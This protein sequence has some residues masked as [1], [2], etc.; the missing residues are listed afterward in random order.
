MIDEPAITT[1]E[2]EPLTESMTHRTLSGMFWLLSGSGVQA[3]LRIAV[4]VIVARLLVPADFGLVAGALVLIDFVEVFSDFGIG[5]V[6]VQRSKLEERHI[7]AGF[8]IS[9]LLGL[10]FAAAI[11]IAAPFAAQALRMEGLTTILRAMV[12]VFPIDSIS[13]VASALLQRDLQFRTLARISVAAYVVGYGLVGVSLAFAGFGVWALVAAYLTQ[14]LFVSIAL[15]IVKPHSKR[16]CFDMATWKE[17]AYMGG[18]FSMAQICNYVALKGDNAIVGR[19]LGAGALGV[20]TRAYGLMTMSVTIFGSA[21]DRV[22]FASLA[23]LQTEKERLAVAFR[24]SVAL[25]T[26]LILPMSV[27]MFLLAPE[28]IGVLLGPKWTEVIMPFQILAV[29]ML[30][31]TGYKVSASVAR[32]TGAVYH[33]AWRQG[34]YGVMVISG[35]L[36]GRIWGV[37]GVAAGVLVALF[38]F[39]LLMAQLSVRL[40]SITWHNYLGAHLPGVALAAVL[41]FETWLATTLLRGM[42]VPQVVVLFTSLAVVTATVVVL[43]SLSPKMVLGEDGLWALCRIAERVPVRFLPLARFRKNLERAVVS[44]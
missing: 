27:V 23:K 32:A 19:W 14:T 29:G 31:R 25:I 40:T 10:A 15:L 3:V 9:A 13:L 24:R 16:P 44:T 21:F 43:L 26:L 2:S 30:F 17:M 18:G 1:A 35:G 5:L 36:I 4:M 6:I 41:G 12:L 37:P 11:W 33:S 38:A 28:L 8:T 39:F 7:R 20:Y 42:N 34:V 22:M